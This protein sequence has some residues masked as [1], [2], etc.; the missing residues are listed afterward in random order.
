MT[1]RIQYRLSAI[2]SAKAGVSS[3]QNRVSRIEYPVSIAQ[4]N[5]F[6][7]NKPNFPNA[8]MNV[9]SAITM[10]YVNI[11]L[12]RRFK[13]K[14]NSKPIQT[15]YKPNQ[16]QFFALFILPMLPIHPNQT[17]F[18]TSPA[19][20]L[21]NFYIYSFRMVQLRNSVLSRFKAPYLRQIS[22]TLSIGRASTL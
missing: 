15:Q 7:Q 9:C 19:Q 8:T 17:Q 5:L 3:I 10:D 20:R 12:R 16:T 6:M 11:R 21:R 13:N 1:S 22:I 4:K 14:A 18:Q 2:A